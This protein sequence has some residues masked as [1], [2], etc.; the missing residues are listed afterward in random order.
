[1]LMVN[2]AM[3]T[4]PSVVQTTLIYLFSYN[5]TYSLSLGR[6]RYKG[7]ER[8]QLNKIGEKVSSGFLESQKNKY[9]E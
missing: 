2:P 6:A 7:G 4:Q 8:V 1:M 3:R 9:K 5:R